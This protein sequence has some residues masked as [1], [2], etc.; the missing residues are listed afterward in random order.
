MVMASLVFVVPFLLLFALGLEGLAYLLTPIAF[1]ATIVLA[2]GAY[3][4]VEPDWRKALGFA[5]REYFPLLI[6]SVLTV[7]ATLFGLA[8]LIFPG[9]FMA[10]SY[11]MALEAVMLEGHGAFSGLGR[12]W[13]LV[14]E[15]RGRIFGVG[16]AFFL[17]IL[18][19]VGIPG[20]IIFAVFGQSGYVVWSGIVNLV[21]LPLTSSLGVAIYFDLRVRKEHLDAQADQLE[22][23]RMRLGAEPA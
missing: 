7:L 16:L 21:F 3:V 4:D 2:A 17:I 6:A 15:H 9:I 18:L 23:I 22:E 5:R 19:V 13:R 14:N 20:A 8:L 10:I 1:G 12:S 11:A